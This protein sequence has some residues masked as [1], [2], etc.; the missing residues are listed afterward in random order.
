[1]D[2]FI[3]Q[4]IEQELRRLAAE[5][6]RELD[7][8]VEMALRQYIVSETFADDGSAGVHTAP[9]PFA[10]DDSVLADD[11]I[12]ATGDLLDDVA[13]FG[14]SVLGDSVLGDSVLGGAVLGGAVLGGGAIP[15][16]D[17]FPTDESVSEG[18]LEIAGL[19]DRP[20]T[21]DSD[22]V[23]IGSIDWSDD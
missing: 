3:D 20:P 14:D 15:G 21:A 4:D 17:P 18:S 12:F 16:D 9:A 22:T 2:F 5:Q 6:G 23:I 11:S 7:E 8:V 1:M 19:G 13:A 10:A